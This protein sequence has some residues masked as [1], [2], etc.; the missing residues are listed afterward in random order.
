ML[1][2][3]LE[4]IKREKYVSKSNIA[5]NLNTTDGVVEHV[6]SQLERMGYIEED[7]GKNC[8]YECKG[9]SFAS[10]CNRVPV[11]TILIT[12]KGKELLNK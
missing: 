4:E 6:I 11:N 1:K 7:S 9:C 12:E 2:E 8:D 10:L 3:V 5:K